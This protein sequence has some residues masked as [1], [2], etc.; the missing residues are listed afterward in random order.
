LRDSYNG[1][2]VLFE[3]TVTR[4]STTFMDGTGDSTPDLS[5]RC[6]QWAM[7]EGILYKLSE[8]LDVLFPSGGG[9]V[10]PRESGKFSV[11]AEALS[12]MFQ[13]FIVPNA[14]VPISEFTPAAVGHVGAGAMLSP[15]PMHE[16]TF[17]YS[18]SD[19][20]I[21]SV[22]PRGLQYY[23][24]GSSED[25][26]VTG[27]DP[28]INNNKTSGM[29]LVPPLALNDVGFGADFIRGNGMRSQEGPLDSIDAT[30]LSAN[31][32]SLNYLKMSQAN[33]GVPV[34]ELKSPG[35]I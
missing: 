2:T 5:T 19:E 29:V 6:I 14:R 8:V 11:N 15:A 25:G 31:R 7:E 12:R 33:S 34:G 22:S 28:R 24:P 13:P 1:L 20:S 35:I 18:E 10:D 23:F 9:S 3:P 27:V 4:A 32:F 17:Y 21:S 26:A 16:P 30:L